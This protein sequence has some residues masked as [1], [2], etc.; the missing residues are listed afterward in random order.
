MDELIDRIVG[1]L[2]AARSILFITGAGISADSGL[3]TYRGVGGLY[4]SGQ[5][6]EGMPIEVLLSGH[7]FQTRPQLT[8]KY[9]S[10]IEQALRG[11]ACNR[12]HQVIAE[13]ERHFER[14]WVLTQ[15]VDGLHHLA[16]SQNVID[17]HGD[18]HELICTRCSFRERVTDY[19]DLTF[20]PRCPDCAGLLRPEV[21]LFG[22]MLPAR[23]LTVL[24]DQLDAGFD[25]VFSIGTSSVFPYIAEPVE[26]AHREDK[27]SVEINPDK[28]EVSELATIRLPLGAAAAL[29]TIWQRFRA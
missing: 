18:M 24:Y 4:N 3:P 12:G 2:R 5:T 22:E 23:Q 7:V 16:G 15:N 1:F 11:A 27:P 19:S 26:R 6:E 25:L 13:M 10:Q 21:V 29:E 20:P 17:I 9:L 28:S 8:W 14:V